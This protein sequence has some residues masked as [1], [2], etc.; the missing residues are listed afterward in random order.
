VTLETRLGAGGDFAAAY[1]IAHE[2]AH[3][4]QNELGIL[5]Q[6]NRARAQAS[7]AQSNALSVRTELQ[8]DCFAGVWAK[9]AQE[10]FDSL[11]RGDIGEAM[12]A[13]AQIGDDTLQRDAGQVVR[14]HTFTHGT[15]EQRQ[16]WFIRG[17]ESGDIASCDT[18]NAPQL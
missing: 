18:F 12:N 16:R 17:Y 3:H 15:A 4:V 8:A 14:P 10:Q 11:E 6:V 13:A 5:D 1:V 9:A 7:E 2:I